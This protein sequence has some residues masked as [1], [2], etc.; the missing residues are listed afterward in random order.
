MKNRTKQLYTQS[1]IIPPQEP[2]TLS[3]DWVRFAT[4]FIK[5]SVYFT[6]DILLVATDRL[7]LLSVPAVDCPVS[8]P[9]TI[10][11]KR[12]LCQENAVLLVV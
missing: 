8:W 7:E 6:G 1:Q 3:I 12:S 11:R 4:E 2:H 9:D 5:G 10:Q